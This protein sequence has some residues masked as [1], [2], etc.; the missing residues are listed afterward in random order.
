MLGATTE[1]LPG[2]YP[3][4]VRL[5]PDQGGGKDNWGTGYTAHG[6]Q[7]RIKPGGRVGAAEF[8]GARVAD[9]C[10]VPACQPA[11]VTIEHWRHGRLDVF[12][13]RIE[14]GLHCFDQT[15]VLEWKE[16]LAACVNP[17]VFSAA[18]AIDLVLGNDDRHW[19]NWLVHNEPNK[20]QP[21][22]YRLRAMDFSRSWPVAHPP[23][24][25]QRHLSRNTWLAL[26]DWNSVGVTFDRHVFHD[27]CARI[28]RLNSRWLKQQVLRPLQGVF[29]TEDE[30]AMLCN[31]W[32]AT[33]QDQVIE[34]IHSLE[35]GVWP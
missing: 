6:E 2:I 34:A 13:S 8:V 29:L 7:F 3:L 4:I 23:H 31:W 9:V 17:K 14:S 25:P 24:H 27:T 26:K 28:G 1:P 18:L 5:D 10:G 20:S 32:H 22:A 21:A 33:I 16:V 12:G 11:V 15:S 19:N 35:T 30:A